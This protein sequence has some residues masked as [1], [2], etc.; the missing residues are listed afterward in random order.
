MAQA[1]RK[2]P[3]SF[4]GNVNFSEMFDL[5]N[6][7]KN[8]ILFLTFGISLALIMILVPLPAALLDFFMMVQF[9]HF[10]CHHFDGDQ[11]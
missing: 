7:F 2:N 9:H 10:I 4:F 5:E 8:S 11:F 1:E 6:L 3:F